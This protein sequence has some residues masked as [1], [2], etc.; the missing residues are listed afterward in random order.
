MSTELKYGIV[1]EVKPGFARISFEDDDIV[2][3][4][5]PVLRRKTKTQKESWQLDINEHVVCLMDCH[6]EEGVVIGAIHSDVD[7]PDS[8]EHPAKFRKIFSDGT[9][10]EYDSE[11]HKLTVDV[12]GDLKATTSGDSE[13]DAATNLKGKAGAK[14]IIE[15]PAIE[16][17]GMVKIT[18]ATTIVGALTVGAISVSAGSGGGGTMDIEGDMNIQG[19]IDATGDV[20]AGGI[21]VKLHKHTGVQTG[22]GVTGPPQ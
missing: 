18:G 15:A 22:P 9:V 2:S 11:A 8:N 4:W 21:S 14:A 12:K 20:T 5:L 16:L 7:T 1:C 6:C 19:K 17:T 13:I 10:I 3:D